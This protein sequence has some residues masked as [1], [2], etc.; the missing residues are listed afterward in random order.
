MTAF[1]PCPPDCGC[2][3]SDALRL[4]G[5]IVEAA[6]D[7]PDM[8]RL[9]PIARDHADAVMTAAY[10]AS[11]TIN[12]TVRN[13]E[14]IMVED[15]DTDPEQMRDTIDNSAITVMISDIMPVGR[16]APA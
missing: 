11:N 13:S 12:I 6:A 7:D 2:S 9:A 8:K 4:W 16:T 15:T 5:L 3:P 10:A 14:N 1:T